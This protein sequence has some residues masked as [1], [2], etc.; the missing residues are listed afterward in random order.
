MQILVNK[1]I[2]QFFIM[3]LGSIIAFILISVVLIALPIDHAE[4][5]IMVSALIMGM[6][7]L[8]AGYWYFR[9]QSKLMEHAITQMKEY[10]SG[11]ENSRIECNDEGELYLLFH[12]INSLVSILNA[13][14]EK[15]MKSK[16]FLRDTLSDISHQLK[17]PLAALNVYHGIIQ[18]EAKDL[19]T[20]KDFTALSEQE[21]DRIETLVQNLLKITK[22]DAGTVLMEKNNENVSDMISD[23][24][25]RFHYR[26]EQEEKRLILAGDD[27][28]TLL[29][30]R[31]WFMEAIS[32][33]VKNAIDHTEKGN[34]VSIEWK[35]FAS[36]VQIIIKD[37]GCGIHPEDLY[38]IFKRFYRSRFS[39][40]TQGVG[41]GLS[42]AKSIIEAHGGTIRVDSELNV[43]TTFVMD[44][45]IPTK[46]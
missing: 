8:I 46:L 23:V 39:K 25:R 18:E 42:L 30:D 22:L 7:I 33:I 37:N 41:L 12:E 20:I 21:L 34:T 44:F 17:T 6:L 31:N 28:V 19:S 24:E 36:I 38:F 2:R 9:N 15:E 5:Y 43:G 27:T 3:V 10:T 32:N 35:Q 16:L 13:H 45:L 4:I 11:N 40:D 14:T 29:C 26:I 1:K